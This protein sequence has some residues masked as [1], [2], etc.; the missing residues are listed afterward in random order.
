MDRIDKKLAK[1]GYEKVEEWED[2]IGYQRKGERY[3]HHV[4]LENTNGVATLSSYFYKDG[5]LMPYPIP[6]FMMIKFIWKMWRK[7]WR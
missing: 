3:I 5:A 2:F 1:L 4:I 7:G 6:I